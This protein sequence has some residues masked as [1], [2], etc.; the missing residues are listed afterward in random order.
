M[1][2]VV[3]SFTHMHRLEVKGQVTPRNTSRSAVAVCLLCTISSRSS[4]RSVFSDE[5]VSHAT[6]EQSP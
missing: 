4:S 6:E 5:H 3:S 2:D 1:H